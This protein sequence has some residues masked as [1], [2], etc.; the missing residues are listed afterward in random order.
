MPSS[1]KELEKLYKQIFETN[2]IL[3]CRNKTL[4]N[5]LRLQLISLNLLFPLQRDLRFNTSD[6]EA[7]RGR[8]SKPIPIKEV[9]QILGVSHRTAQDYLRA[10]RVQFLIYDLMHEVHK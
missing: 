9:M 7:R 8:K 5:F 1:S 3:M 4:F 10:W 2:R 6:Y